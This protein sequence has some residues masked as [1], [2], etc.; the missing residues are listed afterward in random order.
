[1]KSRPAI[2]SQTAAARRRVLIR[3]RGEIPMGIERALNRINNDRAHRR[4][5]D[6]AQR[7]EAVVAID[8]RHFAQITD[9]PVA[10]ERQIVV[11]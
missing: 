7:A 11:W 1:M 10:R 5:F 2:E 6:A 3:E 9:A 4:H 8:G